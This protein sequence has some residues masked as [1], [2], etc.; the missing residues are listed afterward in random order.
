MAWSPPSFTWRAVHARRELGQFPRCVDSITSHTS[1]IRVGFIF[2]DP[3]H[4]PMAHLLQLWDFNGVAGEHRIQHL[5]LSK[6]P[7]KHLSFSPS[8]HPLPF[9][10][11][12]YPDSLESAFPPLFLCGRSRIDLSFFA[13][14]PGLSTKVDT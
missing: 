10:W 4:V 13:L 3:L 14:A 11:E 12:K 5:L 8:R 9:S 1:E 2:L 7:C 6:C